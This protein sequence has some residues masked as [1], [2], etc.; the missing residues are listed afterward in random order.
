MAQLL[1]LRH[2]KSSWDDPSIP[3]HQ[4]PLNARGEQS[5]RAMSNAFATLHLAPDLA[6]ISSSR[7]TQQTFEALHLSLEATET[8]ITDALYLASSDSILERLRLVPGSTRSVLVVGHNPGLYDAAIEL[9]GNDPATRPEPPVMRLL[10]AYPTASPAEFS[11][12]VPWA[13][14]G[15]GRGRLVR[16]QRPE[17][18]ESAAPGAGNARDA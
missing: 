15:P 7:R 9:V 10:D 11:I 3:D 17:D 2:A 5:A 18:F 14:L 8:D 4:R 12:S 13:E 6:L 1:L 16:F